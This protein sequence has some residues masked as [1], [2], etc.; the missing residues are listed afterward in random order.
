MTT[1][2]I[3]IQDDIVAEYGRKRIEDYLVHLS[4][5]LPDQLEV[6]DVLA[7]LSSLDAA[8]AQDTAWQQARVTLGR[9]ASHLE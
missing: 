3:A 8:L 1:F 6:R 2:T 4:A 5:E 9:R 7:E